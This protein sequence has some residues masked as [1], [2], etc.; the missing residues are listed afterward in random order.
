MV[1]GRTL[2][3]LASASGEG[4]GENGRGAPSN[5]SVNCCG[6]GSGRGRAERGSNI[7]ILHRALING[8]CEGRYHIE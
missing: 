3:R 6:E 2:I 8:L 1:R 7:I 4:G 5:G